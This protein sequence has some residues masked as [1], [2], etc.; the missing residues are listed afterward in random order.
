MK[1]P[2]ASGEQIGK[3]CGGEIL[4][5]IKVWKAEEYFVYF[6]LFKL[7]CWGKRSRRRQFVYRL[8]NKKGQ[9]S[10]NTELPRRSAYLLPHSTAVTREI[11]QS[12]RRLLILYESFSRL[13][14]V[15][16]S[17]KR[18]KLLSIST[19]RQCKRCQKLSFCGL[20]AIFAPWYNFFC[21]E[22][23]PYD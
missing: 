17:R 10:L 22:R 23:N 15:T 2:K 20:D 7:K 18:G 13:S 21:K 12:C 5:Q 8:R 3:R 11:R 19:W 6:Q 4:A 14:M 9:S 1:N 16:L